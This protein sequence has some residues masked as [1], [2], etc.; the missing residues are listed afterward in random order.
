MT[1]IIENLKQKEKNL[2]HRNFL[3]TF[4]SRL[5]GEEFGGGEVPPL[6]KSLK[7][8]KD[9]LKT[10]LGKGSCPEQR[11]NYLENLRRFIFHSRL[12]TS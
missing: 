10:I 3:Y 1:T 12:S 4:Y 11:T 2:Q 5:R 6:D 9:E 7:S 8:S